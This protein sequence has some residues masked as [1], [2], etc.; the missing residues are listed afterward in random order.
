MNAKL[1]RRKAASKRFVALCRNRRSAGASRSLWACLRAEA[2]SATPK[3]NLVGRLIEN[4]GLKGA[5][6]G[7]AQIS[8]RHANFIVNKG[9]AKAVE[10]LSL[11]HAA[12]DAVAERYGV[13]LV[14][15]VRFLGF[16]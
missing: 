4:V 8:E 6:C 3:A 13:E 12:S 16:E 15:E 5:L 9:G 2:F 1:R 10:V 7:G 14:P 11:I